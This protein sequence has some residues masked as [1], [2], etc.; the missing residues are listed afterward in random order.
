MIA[1]HHLESLFYRAWLYI[2]S[3]PMIDL[4][5][6]VNQSKLQVSPMNK[7]GYYALRHK[8]HM[9]GSDPRADHFVAVNIEV[10]DKCHFAIFST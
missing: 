5:D 10:H 7:W 9:V 4:I 2:C 3:V 6:H 8:L 1:T